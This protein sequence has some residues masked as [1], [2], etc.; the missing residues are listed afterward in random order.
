E[1]D[2][3]LFVGGSGRMPRFQTVMKGLFGPSTDVR[4]DVEPDEA[5]SI[6][7]ATQAAMILASNVD[8]AASSTN[9][10]VKA[11]HLTKSI[12]LEVAGGAFAVLV[13]RLAVVPARRTLE[14]GVAEDGQKEIYLAVYEGDDKVAKKNSL[15]AEIVLGELPEGLKK[16]EGKI[17]VSFTIEADQVLTVFAKEK[18]KGAH[19][20]VKV[21]QK[22]HK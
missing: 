18:S 21:H 9:D 3:V 7:C 17:E 10:A 12:G 14:F 5:I 4:T 15:L 22:E 1:V 19:I 16:G 20:K 2:E 11:P 6:G 13:P 8:Y